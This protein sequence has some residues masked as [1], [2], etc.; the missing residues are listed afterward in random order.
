MIY[1]NI[2]NWFSFKTVGQV[3][4]GSCE[5]N[6]VDDE[7]WC[8][9]FPLAGL[10]CVRSAPVRARLQSVRRIHSFIYPEQSLALPMQMQALLLAPSSNFAQSR[11]QPLPFPLKGERESNRLPL[12]RSLVALLTQL[13]RFLAALTM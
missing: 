2:C 7:R 3:N 12:C 8:A 10:A 13:D 9:S 6:L 4:A 1:G 11:R 5:R